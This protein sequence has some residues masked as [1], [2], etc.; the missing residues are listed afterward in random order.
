M[1][2]HRQLIP[3]HLEVVI[4]VVTLLFRHDMSVLIRRV[5]GEIV[6]LGGEEVRSH[7]DAASVE[8]RVDLE[9]AL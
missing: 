9:D 6:P 3:R 1:S 5:G 2:G 4:V 7:G 8:V